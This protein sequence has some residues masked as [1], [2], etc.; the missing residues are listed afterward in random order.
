LR[1]HDANIKIRSGGYD[2]YLCMFQLY[3]I[4]FAAYINI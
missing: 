1:M 4:F 3:S 2:S